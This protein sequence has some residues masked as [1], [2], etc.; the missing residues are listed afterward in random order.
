MK[1]LLLSLT[2]GALLASASQSSRAWEN[3]A[4][5]S[6]NNSANVKIL[7]NGQPPHSQ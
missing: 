4:G 3:A 7:F 5:E 2:A 6:S 1:R